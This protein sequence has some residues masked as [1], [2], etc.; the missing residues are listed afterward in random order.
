MKHR[1]NISIGRPSSERD[2]SPRVGHDGPVPKA[3][4]F[5]RSQASAN[6][7]GGLAAAGLFLV[8]FGGQS[9]AQVL[10]Q[11]GFNASASVAT[12]V[13]A[14]PNSGQFN[15]ITGSGGTVVNL[16]DIGFEM[17]NSL[18]FDRSGGAGAGV[19][20]RTTDL[21]AQ[22]GAVKIE[23]WFTPGYF[24]SAATG[25]V[26][27]QVGS[28]FATAA[29]VETTAR[30][31]ASVSVDLRPFASTFGGDWWG[32]TGSSYSFAGFQGDGF[33]RVTWVINNRAS[34]V[35]YTNSNNQAVTL[36]ANKF[37]LWMG[38]SG[39]AVQVFQGVAVANSTVPLTDFKMVISGGT[40]LYALDEVTIEQLGLLADPQITLLPP[41]VGGGL[42][43]LPASGTPGSTWSVLRATS[44]TGPWTTN[45]SALLLDGS[46]AGQY[47]D[48]SPPT[49][50]AFYRAVLP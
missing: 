38:D 45:S 15:A 42:V 37:D 34:S 17:G 10:L 20:A 11:Q 9:E 50:A 27:F 43:T 41:L 18:V 1:I 26:T 29:T 30:A 40:A 8:L 7:C 44:L 46:G 22:P 31:A 13:N 2:H 49:G 25:V 3:A 32:W 33:P 39:L 24:A 23:F 19:V 21:A 35:T 12:Y 48:N 6:R 36:D 28:N 47:Q 4:A 16:Q 14:S 5:G